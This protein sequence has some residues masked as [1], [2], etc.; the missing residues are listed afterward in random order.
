MGINLSGI[1]LVAILITLCFTYTLVG[2]YRIVHGGIEIFSSG[3]IT[4]WAMRNSYQAVQPAWGFGRSL[5][6]YPI[7]N[8]IFLW[9]FPIITLFEVFA[10]VSLF[11]RRFR[12]VFLGVMIPFHFLSWL[13][14]E[15]FF[16]ANLLL[17]ILFFDVDKWLAPK[18]PSAKHN[19]IFFDSLCGF[20][21]CFMTWVLRRDRT[22]IYKFSSLQGQTALDMLN[23]QDR[24]LEKCSIVLVDEAGIHKRSDAVI[25]ILS[26]LGGFCRVGAVALLYTPKAIRGWLYDFTVQQS[27]RLFRKSAM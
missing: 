19:I 21:N 7:F 3:S 2:V 25:G 20:S 24:D 27:H 18:V 26:G 23:P 22:G 13:F 6:E 12:C 1:P 5:L 14:M 10:P 8:S 4:F 15:V 16:W 17:F 9:G 11:S